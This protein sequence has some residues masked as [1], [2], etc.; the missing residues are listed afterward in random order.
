MYDLFKGVKRIIFLNIF[1]LQYGFHEINIRILLQ[2]WGW[3]F[4]NLSQNFNAGFVKPTLYN[5]FSKIKL[6]LFVYATKTLHKRKEKN[7][8]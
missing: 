4:A 1:F 7:I 5:I 3:G 2:K 6:A 8:S